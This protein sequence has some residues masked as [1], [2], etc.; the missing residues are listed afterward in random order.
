MIMHESWTRRL[1]KC[2]FIDSAYRNLVSV[3]RPW[4]QQVN[5]SLTILNHR[6]HWATA[7]AILVQDRLLS[8]SFKADAMSAIETAAAIELTH[9]TAK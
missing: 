5:A 4:S 7:Q 2:R 9:P 3:N 6:K 1:R 8:Q